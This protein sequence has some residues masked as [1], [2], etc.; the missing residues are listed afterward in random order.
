MPSATDSLIANARCIGECVPQGFYLP[1]LV[2]L[3]A[4]LNGMSTPINTQTLISNA[5]CVQQCVPPGMLLP[6]L[7][8]LVAG[9]SGGPQAAGSVIGGTGAPVNP[10]PNPALYWIYNDLSPAGEQWWWNPAAQ[11]W[12]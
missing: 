4:Q 8:S 12:Q 1:I 9:S 3:Y 11:T 10:P 2:S 7:I 5:L 6:V